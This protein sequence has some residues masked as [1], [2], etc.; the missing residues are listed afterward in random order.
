MPRPTAD[1]AGTAS[2]AFNARKITTARGPEPR[3]DR[4]ARTKAVILDVASELFATRGFRHTSVK[5]IAEAVEMTK[6]AV[7]FHY[8]TKEALAVA[9]VEGH[10]AYWPRLLEDVQKRE[11]PPLETALAMLDGAALA[12]R[13][14]VVV[15]GGARLQIER[16]HIDAELP[17]P[18]V[19]WTELLRS[20]L[21]DAYDKGQLA[22]DVDPGAAARSLV[23]AF[24]GVQHVSDV[25]HG[26]ADITDRW[27]ETR[28]LFLRALR[29]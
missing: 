10:Y 7:Y 16:P 9:V 14:N 12:F 29:P 28:D 20:L 15:R 24:F 4:S 27:A 22:S 3:Q 5:D 26:R 21:S 6:G 2:V 23:S 11:L 25:L 8:P 18:Y 17:T 1:A 19:D 13:D